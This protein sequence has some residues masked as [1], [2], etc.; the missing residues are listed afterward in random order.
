MVTVNFNAIRLYYS[1]NEEVKINMKNIIKNLLT[2]TERE[3]LISLIS[4]IENIL[5][6]KFIALTKDERQYYGSIKEQNKLL[7]NKVRDYRQGSP[8]MSSPDINW[9]EFESDYQARLFL[10][11]LLSR[12][13]SLSYRLE[14][15]K[16]LHDYD[17]YQDSLREYSYAQYKR[18]IQESGYAEKVADLKQFFSRTGT[19]LKGKAKNNDKNE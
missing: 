5:R 1:A 8:S 7:V 12:L 14:S 16:I 6:G 10:E 13:N 11:G 2:Q 9:E 18:D 17:N 19:G 4:Q 15:A 3:E